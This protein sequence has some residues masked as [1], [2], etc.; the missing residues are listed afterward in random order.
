MRTA[1]KGLGQS[2]FRCFRKGANGFNGDMERSENMTGAVL[3]MASMAAFTF[4]DMFMKLLA[5]GLPLYQLLFLRGVVTTVVIGG[6]AWWVG[7]SGRAVARR[8]WLVIAM[9]TL[10]EMGAAF[11]FISALINTPL[12]NVTAI[13]QALPL[14]MT[15]AAALVFRDPVGWRRMAAIAVGFCG[16][17]LIVRPGPEGIDVFA[18]Y[19][20]AA[21]AC[22]TVRDLSTRK[23]SRD[24]PSMLVSFATSIAMMVTFGLA[25][26]GQTWVD[27]DVRQVGLIGGASLC[28]IGGYIT[29]IMVMRMGEISFVAPFRYTALIW[30][31]LLGWLVF[32]H[33]PDPLTLLGGAIVVASGLFT[34]YREAR[35]I[36]RRLRARALRPR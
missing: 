6:I 5:E 19:G 15:L 36:R 24:V 27:M 25:T 10:A 4:S 9:R 22:V 35:D 26:M 20:L 14:T 33:W 18:L 16:V 31:L 2:R 8:D 32:G 7:T 23:L 34:L 21:V 30:A 1:G 3:M 29:S 17:M 28:V 11:F 12:A 13:M